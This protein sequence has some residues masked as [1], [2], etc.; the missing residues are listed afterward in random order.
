MINDQGD[1]RPPGSLSR[2]IDSYRH[3]GDALASLS[4]SFDAWQ[5]AVPTASQNGNG[6]PAD[7]GTKLPATDL[8][9][10]SCLGRFSLEL[11]GTPITIPSGG[12][13]LAVLKYLAARAGRPTPR[14]MLLEAL[15]PD[16]APDASTNRLRV[17]V[18]ALR[19]DLGTDAAHLVEHQDGCYAFGPGISPRL[20]TAEFEQA[21]RNGAAAE[22]AGDSQ[23]AMQ[24]LEIAETLYR[25]DFLE[26]DI[27]EDWT[28][29]E[30][31]FLRDIFLNVLAQ[32]AEHSLATGDYT[33]CQDRCRQ[34]IR[35]DVCN[36]GAYRLLME[37]H[38]RV[39]QPGRALHWYS[40]C[41][42]NLKRELDIEP[43]ERLIE[44]KASIGSRARKAV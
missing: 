5:Q 10:V 26:D 1:I 25:G 40:I 12:R 21:W 19:R 39:G 18:H 41:E 34:L 32:L 7:V 38:I 13:P 17:A 3:A 20:D 35:H 36:E 9:K 42:A 29:V 22:R 37:S 28:L 6:V 31:E 27:Y 33:A 44:L 43:S 2:V 14:D 30:R 4:S 15:W 23:S 8:V 11:N 24:F 16:A